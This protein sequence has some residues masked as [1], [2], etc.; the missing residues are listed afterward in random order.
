MNFSHH[1]KEVEADLP[2]LLA[3]PIVRRAD[4]SKICVWISTSKNV[5]TKIRIFRIIRSANKRSD[6][7]RDSNE[8]VFPRGND[9]I[10]DRPNLQLIGEGI[11]S[12]IQLGDNLFV[13]LVIASPLKD[14]DGS[15]DSHSI[16][17]LIEF[18]TNELIAYDLEL[19]SP[20]SESGDT[21]TISLKDLGLLS[22]ENSI[23][24]GHQTIEAS[25]SSS[26]IPNSNDRLH[27]YPSLPMFYIPD[28]VNSSSLNLL[29]GSCRKL[30]GDDEDSL[31]IGD[32]LMQDLTYDLAKRPSALFLMGDQ[33]YADNV[34]DPLIDF[35]KKLSSKILGWEEG[36]NGVDKKLDE[37]SAGE[38]KEVVGKYAKF[39]TDEGHN[40]LLGFGEFA[41]MYLVAWN[42]LLWP[43]KFDQARTSDLTN[44]S[45]IKK[46]IKES[47]ELEQSRR[48][49]VGIRRLLANIPTYMICDDH[50]ITDD[51]NINKK[52]RDDVDQS[53]CGKQ[54]IS[55]GL[56]AFWAFQ[57]WGNDPESFEE[58]FIQKVKQYLY[59][60]RKSSELF[61]Q[62]HEEALAKS[63]RTSP[64]AK[65]GIIN[66]EMD[67]DMPYRFIMST[68]WTFVAPTY[69]LSVF[70][71][72]RTQ[73]AFVDEEGPPHLLSDKALGCMKSM[74]IKSGYKND[75]PIILVSPTP[76]F[77]FELAESIQHFL[78]SISGSYKWDLETWR[79]NEIGFVK[80]LAYLSN[81]FNPSYC[82]F[83]SG[84]VHYAFTMK[85]HFERLNLSQE[86]GSSTEMT[87]N[88]KI[89]S[90]MPIVQLTSSPF[91]SNSLRNRIA[92]ILI[93]NL[94]HK[95]IVSKNFLLRRIMV[96][97]STNKVPHLNY[98][99]FKLL[100]N[101]HDAETKSNSL[102]NYNYHKQK[103][104]FSKH[105]NDK[106]WLEKIK[107][108][109]FNLIARHLKNQS[110]RQ[111][112]DS[113]W[114][115]HRL[116]I[117]PRGQGTLP[118]LARNNIGYVH[119][120]LNSKYV[121]HTHYFLDKDKVRNSQVS[122]SFQS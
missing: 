118:V 19:V 24:Y 4:R 120:D 67:Q 99:Y 98:D 12:P 62:V 16:G 63:H 33:I 9:A 49:L 47:K 78:T 85:A 76:V 36:L 57:A 71:D 29:Y 53:I 84:D 86:I 1:F 46:Y 37:L 90:A 17:N 88:K 91:R 100:P 25:L 66:M 26:S 75:D 61:S 80:F 10:E 60:N 34:A 48:S 42:Q 7:R 70:L 113:P 59:L 45:S 56:V 58:G 38:R 95:V 114:A 23:V 43:S 74:M 117:K 73:R 13:N 27:H 21:K 119:L 102:N 18:P 15:R 89:L 50:E 44:S 104:Y 39:S 52:W 22:G 32:K 2:L 83:L 112:A 116:L 96:I 106:S 68:N 79:A 65:D 28:T 6:K 93:L 20:A 31:V 81:N 40:H 77:G 30:Y 115:E 55:N 92:A 111:L 8:N 109:S 110:D 3:G 72:C 94:V 103:I 122:V 35:I 121:A 105:S 69:P 108:I 107:M 87:S 51:W 82:I 11:N 5:Q 97:K 41:A 14:Q 64:N 54:V 101:I